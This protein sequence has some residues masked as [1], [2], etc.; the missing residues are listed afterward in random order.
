MHKHLINKSISKA[1]ILFGIRLN[2]VFQGPYQVYINLTDHCNLNCLMCSAYSPLV[3]SKVKDHKKGF[4]RNEI[5]DKLADSLVALKVSLA[6]LTGGGEPFLHPYLMDFVRILSDAKK[7]VTIV[8]N[9]TLIKEGQ[10]PELL[11]RDIN[12]RFS[13][14]AASPDTYVEVHP[15]QTPA[16][17]EKLRNTL[18]LIRD[19]RKKSK[20]RSI[21]SILF[22]IFK[23]NFHEIPNMLHMGKEYEVDFVHFKP[24]IFDHEKMKELFLDDVQLRELQDIIGSVKSS[25]DISSTDLTT[26][27]GDLEQNQR[28]IASRSEPGQR[29]SIPCFKGWT[30][31]W[32]LATGDVVPCCDCTISLGSINNEP[33]ENIWYSARYSEIRR[34]MT[35][36]H[37]GFISLPGCRCDSC[38]P[39]SEELKISK[40]LRLI[41]RG[42]GRKTI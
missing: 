22:V 14:I 34:S 12:L 16:T 33:F 26:M 20:S 30:F 29:R 11:K 41:G 18:A 40:G 1:R 19:V 4:L 25:H 10:V 42:S 32:I 8:T 28:R 2:K 5:L 39:D 35:T 9:G 27:C 17:F 6:T 7:D 23:S 31:C 38:R 13:L 21:I 15:N 36:L 24:A 37:Q 3:E